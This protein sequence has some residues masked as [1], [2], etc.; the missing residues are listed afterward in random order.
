M[1]TTWNRGAEAIFGY[2]PAEVIGKPVCILAAMGREDEM[3]LMRERIKRGEQIEHYETI[4]RCKQ[5]REI[6]VSLTVSPICDANGWIVGVSKIA[7]DISERKQAEAEL[8]EL[9]ETLERRVSERTAELE[10][11]NQRLRAEIAEREHAD[12]RLQELQS[13]LFHAARLSAVGQM[14]GALAH[15]LNQPLAAV[16]NFVNAARRLLASGEQE[17]LDA[18]RK[19]MADAGAEVLRAGQIIRR[20]RDFVTLGET[21]RQPE[22]VIPLIEE[23]SALALTGAGAAGVRA[24]FRFDP[25]AARAFANRVQIQQVLVNLIRNAVDA[26]TESTRRELEVR[27]TWLD[28]ETIEIA[29]AD[30][31][32]GIPGDVR[33]RLFEPFVSTKANGMGLGLSI[34]RSIVEAHGGRLRSEPNHSAGTIFLFTLP[35]VPKE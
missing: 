7:R 3:P 34:C 23:S 13:E 6:A 20:L 2:R 21:D 27:T 30:S 22:S 16:T 24:F 32:P 11:A 4:R 14:A 25:K 12:T 8:V 35:S 18:A 15:E 5:G 9:N 10:R 1:I 17:K 29:V 19:V 33:D 31:G 28:D 26:M